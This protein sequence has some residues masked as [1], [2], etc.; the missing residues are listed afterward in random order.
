M[1]TPI[2]DSETLLSRIVPQARKTLE[3]D[4]ALAPLAATIDAAGKF[5]W[6][7]IPTDVAASADR[8][9]PLLEDGIAELAGGAA[10]R[11]AVLAYATQV[12]LPDSEEVGEAIVVAL[13][14]SDGYAV[15]L[16]YPFRRE[17]G[18]LVWGEAFA[19]E[20]QANLLGTRG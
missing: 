3:Q 4:G 14:H 8:L 17:G 15:D 20:S 18:N 16:Y 2:E 1:P 19:G 5:Q 7:A 11:A 9:A 10:G 12:N 13:A 6:L